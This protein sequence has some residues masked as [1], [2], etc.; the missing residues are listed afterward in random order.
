MVPV[1]GGVG[2]LKQGS[3]AVSGPT[4]R[5]RRRRGQVEPGR[6]SAAGVRRPLRT[7]LSL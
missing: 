1:R 6:R 4:D 5:A 2:Q 3:G 7:D